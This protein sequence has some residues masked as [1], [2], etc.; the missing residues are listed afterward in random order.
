[1]R[2]VHQTPYP[3][4][5]EN[6]KYSKINN[7]SHKTEKQQGPKKPPAK[8]QHFISQQNWMANVSQS[9]GKYILKLLGHKLIISNVLTNS[10]FKVEWC[11]QTGLPRIRNL[12]RSKQECGQHYQIQVS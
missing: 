1:M 8:S 12:A 2:N 3:Y 4:S 10:K 9:Q 6:S 5:F 7:A 11:K